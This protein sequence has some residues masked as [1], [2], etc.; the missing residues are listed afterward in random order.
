MNMAGKAVQITNFDKHLGRLI[1]MHR[2]CHA[3][4]QKDLARALG[5]SF[6]QIQKYETAAN[7]ISASRLHDL[8]RYLRVP[9]GAFLQETNAEYIQNPKMAQIIQNLYKMSPTHVDMI[10]QLTNT[11]RNLYAKTPDAT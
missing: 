5:C 9:M 2:A 4:S 3:L 1:A 8:C 11:L 6:Q 7:R 10:L